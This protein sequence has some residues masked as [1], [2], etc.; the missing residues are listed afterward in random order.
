MMMSNLDTLR[1]D[2]DREW[3]KYGVYHGKNLITNIPSW[4]EILKTLN[5]EIRR[6]NPTLF[7]EPSNNDFEIV[8]KDMIAM[9]KLYFDDEQ[10]LKNS[11][12]ANLHGYGIESEATFFFSLFFEK[13]R[14][15]EIL[16]EST[17]SDIKSINKIIDV[18]TSFTS[19][20]VSLA[21]KLTPFESHVGHTCIVQLSGLSFWKLRDKEVGL[22]DL[23]VVG[24]GD[25]LFFKEN[26]EHE[27]SN[28]EPRSSLV[29]RFTFGESHG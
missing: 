4:E 16:P 5:A 8:Y 10:L 23:Y 21:D 3:S 2:F 14:L 26:V 29:G 25:Y 19:L 27:L 7:T 24:P 28:E 12:E 9:K 6:P 18:D 17:I 15:N 11:A 20:K 1:S 22:D 13:D